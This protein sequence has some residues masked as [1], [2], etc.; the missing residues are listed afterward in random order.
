MTIADRI[1]QRSPAVRGSL[2]VLLLLLTV[3]LA[4]H[5]IILPIRGIPTSQ[6]RWRVHARDALAIARGQA[7]EVPTL[8]SRLKALPI[9]PIWQRFYPE[10][11]SANASTAFREDITRCASVAG[12]TVDSIAPLAATEQFGL[13]RLGMRIS[14]ITT[15]GQ[16]TSFLTQLRRSPRYLRVDALR[17]VAPQVQMKNVNERLLVQ[18][19]IFGYTRPMRESRE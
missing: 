17:V 19:Q 15:I 5:D 13:R 12:V 1:A 10:G 16:L 8:Q 9:A 3:T 2:A 7:A 18:L 6:D 11:D 14:A 4:W